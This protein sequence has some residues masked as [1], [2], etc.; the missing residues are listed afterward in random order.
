MSSISPTGEFILFLNSMVNP[1]LIYEDL[2]YDFVFESY[3]EAT[4]DNS[5]EMSSFT[6]AETHQKNRTKRELA[7]GLAKQE[8]G[9]AQQLENT[10]I[11]NSSLSTPKS[12]HMRVQFTDLNQVSLERITDH[13]N[14]KIKRPAIFYPNF[15]KMSVAEIKNIQQIKFF[16]QVPP[17]IEQS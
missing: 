17:Q 9:F 11:V 10:I 15:S 8:L 1:F 14:L 16:K 2:K 4:V 6:S 12:I 13:L 5:K 3:M 7:Q